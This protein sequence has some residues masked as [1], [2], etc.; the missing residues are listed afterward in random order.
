MPAILTPRRFCLSQSCTVCTDQF[1][2]D[3]SRANGEAPESHAGDR[4]GY[5]TFNAQSVRVAAIVIT[6]GD[7][8]TGYNDAPLHIERVLANRA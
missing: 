2:K 8:I 1:H 5:V 6:I 4:S 7:P 3:G